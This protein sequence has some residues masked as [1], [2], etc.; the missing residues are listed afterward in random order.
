MPH[1]FQRD[2]PQMQYH[3]HRA[4]SQFRNNSHSVMYMF[5]KNDQT[6]I[7]ISKSDKEFIDLFLKIKIEEIKILFMASSLLLF[8]TEVINEY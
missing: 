6:K 4:K 1:R 5:Y 8:R 3:F 7:N 2:S